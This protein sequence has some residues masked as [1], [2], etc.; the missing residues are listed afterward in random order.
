MLS[1]DMSKSWKWR[2]EMSAYHEGAEKRSP[3]D[4]VA[5]LL[6]WNGHR[7]QGLSAA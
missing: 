3:D 2:T 5:M 4:A 1:A 7:A 6:A